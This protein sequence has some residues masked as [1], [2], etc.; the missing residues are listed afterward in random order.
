LVEA[1]SRPGLSRREH[2]LLVYNMGRLDR[3][4]VPPLIAAL[5]SPDAALAA[6]AAAV[7]G[8]IGDKEAVPHLTFPAAL[9]GAAPVL[10]TAAQEAIAR[11]TGRPYSAQPLSPVQVLTAAA[12]RYHRHQVEFPNEPVV[13]WAWDN[14]RKS[15]VPR[16]VPRTEAEAIFGLRL[17]KEALQLNP[18]YRPAQVAQLSLALEKAIERAGYTEFPS[19]DRA[20]FTAATA[21]GPAVLSEVLKTAIADGKTD[22]AATAAIALGQVTDRT[23]LASTGRPHPLVEALWAPGRR[24]QFA[25]AK[26]LATLAPTQPFPGSS[27]VVPTLARFVINQALPRAIVIDSNPNRGSQLAGFLMNLGYDAELELTGSEGFRAAT[28]TADVELI[29]VSFDLFQGWGLNDLLA[30]FEADARTAA[31]PLFIYGPL[32]L[33]IKRP[34]LEHAYPGIKYVVQPADAETLRQ[35]LKGLPMTLPG[36]ERA[37]YAREAAALLARIATEQKGPL[38]SDLAAA[39]PALSVALSRAETGPAAATALGAVPD[40]DAQRSLAEVALDPSRTP[41]L[42]SRAAVQLVRSI[43]RFGRLVTAHQEA[44]LATTL[45][46]ETNPDVRASLMDIVRALRPTPPTGPPRTPA[47]TTPPTPIAP[48]QPGANR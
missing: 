12:W 48:P 9:A 19:K 6:D 20:S 47:A 38:A 33:P 16:T 43:R 13:I 36:A 46:E 8:A 25:A 27:R 11:L 15:P 17:A 22:L 44:R 14:E 2:R 41:A 45:R 37:G 4:A 3:S 18:N 23:A 30:N 28:E 34:N 10:R 35:Q 42:R 24:V 7:L 39:V 21:S 26:A 29:L 1:L 31:I 32:D 40:P 5:D